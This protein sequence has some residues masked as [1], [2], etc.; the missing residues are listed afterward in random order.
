MSIVWMLWACSTPDPAP[1]ARPSLPVSP[2]DDEGAL[3]RRRRHPLVAR[4]AADVVTGAFPLTVTFDP[5][6]SRLGWGAV[7]SE[8]SFGDGAGSTDPGTV[9]HTYVGA[10]TFDATLTLVDDRTGRVST[11][12]VTIDVTAPPC[13]VGAAP[14]RWGTVADSALNEISG[15]VASRREPDAYWVQEDSGN[16]AVLTAIDGSGA[17]LSEH[18]L[19]VAFTDWEDLQATVD[20]ATGTPTLFL[21][22]FGDNGRSRGSVSVWVVDEPDPLVDGPLAPFE[23]ELRY[24]DGPHDA[25]TLLVD[26]LTGDLFVVTKESA[27]P[28]RLYVKRAPQD[29]PGAF[30]LDALGAPAALSFAATS[31]DVSADGDRVVVRGYSTTAALFV[32]DGYLPL[33]DAFSS[34]ICPITLAGEV[35][36]EAIGFTADGSAL[37]TTSEGVRQPVSAVEL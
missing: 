33:E 29:T 16:A 25:E 15:L 8:W 30:V 12:T 32:R 2:S 4:V 35:Q 37:V 7:Q 24:P 10:G 5:S 1:F 13:P 17:T 18:A 11:A 6:A 22:D 34:P 28:A 14:V 27:G 26:P 36:G 3:D 20:P 31:G 19:S 9:V 21:A 23:L